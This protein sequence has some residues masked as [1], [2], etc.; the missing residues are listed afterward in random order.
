MGTKINQFTIDQLNI[1]LD[2]RFLVKSQIN[3]TMSFTINGINS[4]IK[5]SNVII[6][7]NI[8]STM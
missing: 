6:Y 8:G 5:H 7:N 2:N 1:T 3:V 4:L